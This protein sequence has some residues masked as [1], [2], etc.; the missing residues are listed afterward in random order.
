MD[1]RSEEVLLK[2]EFKVNNIYRARGALLL[3]TNK[4]LKLY[5]RYTGSEARLEFENRVKGCLIEQGYQNVDLYRANRDGGL[6]TEDSQGERYVIRDWF[7]GTECNLKDKTEAGEAAQSLAYIHKLLKKVNQI[8]TQEEHREKK[9]T[10]VF[11]RHN[12][13]LKRVRSYILDKKQK[14]EFEVRFLNVFDGFYEQGKTAETLLLR[15]GYDKLLEEAQSE[16]SVYHGAYNYHN[17]L[18]TGG[19]IAVTNFNKSDIGVQVLD[20]YGFLRKAMEKNNWDE[21]LGIWI[22]ESYMKENCLDKRERELL[23][24]LSLY[25]EKFWKITNYY[26]NNKKSWIS[27]RNTQKLANIQQQEKQKNQFLR[28]ME[29]YCR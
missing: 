14:N 21:E 26:F 2:Y 11:S 17:I 27:S 4:G 28:K 1:D 24:I 23:Y 25:P 15:S 10:D 16:A 22:I 12:K 13:E 3:D 19:N 7:Q 29:T 20:L 8:K 9:L 5:G 6:V 18:F